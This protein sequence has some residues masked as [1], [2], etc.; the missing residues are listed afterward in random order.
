MNF[1]EFFEKLH[2]MA[3]SKIQTTTLAQKNDFQDQKQTSLKTSVAI[4]LKI[5]NSSKVKIIALFI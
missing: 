2:K 5:N 4:K 1:L 3:K